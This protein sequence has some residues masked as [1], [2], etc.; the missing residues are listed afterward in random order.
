M[1][2]SNMEIYNVGSFCGCVFFDRQSERLIL[3]AFVDFM[4]YWGWKYL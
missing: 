4:N 1:M 3:G 2:H